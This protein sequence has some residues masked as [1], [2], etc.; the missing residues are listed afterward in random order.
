MSK[1]I[2]PLD[3]KLSQLSQQHDFLPYYD[4]DFDE[5]ELNVC[6]D[7][8]VR[9]KS[10]FKTWGLQIRV[11]LISEF[12][13]TLAVLS[14]ALDKTNLSECIFLAIDPEPSVKS[15]KK[16]LKWLDYH[17]T[18]ENRNASDE[19]RL[20][21]D[22]TFF[23]LTRQGHAAFIQTKPEIK[24]IQHK[25]DVK[26][27]R[28]AKK[29]MKDIFD[30]RIELHNPSARPVKFLS[31]YQELVEIG[32]CAEFLE[33]HKTAWHIRY[34]TNINVENDYPN[35]LYLDGTPI[36]DKDPEFNDWLHAQTW[37]LNDPISQ[38]FSHQYIRENMN[39]DKFPDSLVEI[40]SNHIGDIIACCESISELQQ[41]FPDV[42][43]SHASWKAYELMQDV[44][45]HGD[46]HVKNEF[47]KLCLEEPVENWGP[48]IGIPDGIW[49]LEKTPKHREFM[50]IIAGTHNKQQPVKIQPIK[51]KL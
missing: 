23:C 22:K 44:W 26:R 6:R 30:Y 3:M 42:Y 7:G 47:S 20:D 51:I 34:S 33:L 4:D 27:I 28:D 36:K 35:P 31:P 41:Q 50:S 37:N 25:F 48:N 17:K 15:I 24:D 39:L 43:S 8:Y 9:L 32:V 13:Q 46:D 12:S 11:D 2:T 5:N 49:T 40:C 10:Y 18:M 29:Q 19:E 1:F 14:S 21:F 16:I 38:H 45:I